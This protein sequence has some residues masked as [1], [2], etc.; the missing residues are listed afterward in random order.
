[1]SKPL[2]LAGFSGLPVALTGGFVRFGV[3]GSL[4]GARTLVPSI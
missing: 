2:I 4:F 3:R 1:M